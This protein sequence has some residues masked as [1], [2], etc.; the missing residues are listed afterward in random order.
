METCTALHWSSMND[1]VQDADSLLNFMA[2]TNTYPSLFDCVFA[3][4]TWRHAQL[5]TGAV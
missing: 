1:Y 5:Y 2:L 4:Q 3:G